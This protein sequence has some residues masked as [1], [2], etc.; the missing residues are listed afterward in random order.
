MAKTL[1][2]IGKTKKDTFHMIPRLDDNGHPQ[3]LKQGGT[4]QEPNKKQRVYCH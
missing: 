3:R 2:V 4:E 1:A